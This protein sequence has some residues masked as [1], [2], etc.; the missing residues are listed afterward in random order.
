[1]NSAELSITELT[2][3]VQF[4]VDQQGH[5]TAVVVQPL[6]W[7]YIVDTLAEAGDQALVQALRAH[8][9]TNPDALSYTDSQS[10]QHRL[11]RFTAA[12][13]DEFLNGAYATMLA[14][15][16]VLR[17]D[18]DTPEEDAAWADL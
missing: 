12:E 6:L 11:A 9:L 18:W 13:E 1:M 2:E 7:R 3:N 16:A 4:T 5:V 8:N 10:A 14:S 15:E 17:N